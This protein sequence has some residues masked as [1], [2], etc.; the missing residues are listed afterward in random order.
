MQNIN[1]QNDEI[2]WGDVFP[3][4]YAYA[5]YLLEKFVWFRGAGTDVYLEGKTVDDYVYDAIEQYLLNPGKYD[6]S[7]GRSLTNYI[8]YHILLTLIGNDARS[9]ENR[10]GVVPV[11]GTSDE[12]EG[13]YS[14]NILLGVSEALFDQEIDLDKVIADIEKELRSDDIAERIFIG[15]RL[16][17]YSRKDLIK[18]TGLSSDEFDNGMRRLNTVLKNTAKKF[19]LKK[20]TTS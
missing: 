5:H 17:G 8:K 11:P 2:D 14:D 16:L 12:E 19:Q 3:R 20:P 13:D 9:Q 18:Q 7:T 10:R 6:P 4:L 1:P 15:L